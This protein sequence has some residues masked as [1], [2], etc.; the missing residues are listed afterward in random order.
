MLKLHEL[1]HR[2]GENTVLNNISLTLEPGERVALM[3][4]SGCG[5]TTLL[6]L[7][8]GLLQPSEGQ[9][10]NTFPKTGVVF[11]EP[12]LLAWRTAL[13]NVN[14]VL[15]DKAE[16][17]SRSLSCLTQ[18]ELEDAAEKYPRELSG[19]MQQRVALARAFVL[20]PDLLILDEPFK[21]LDQELRMRIL[22]QI[23]KTQAA[24][25]LVTHDPAEAQAL[26]CRV[27]SLG[28]QP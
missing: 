16:T 4:P 12:R 21:G 26:G 15:G 20:D 6:R 8:L 22:R 19:G 18:M 25:L 7:A 2:Y 27:L 9:A 5:K 10:E 11:Q 24:I 3:G 17:L 28:Q 13:D 1:T 14:L 23:G